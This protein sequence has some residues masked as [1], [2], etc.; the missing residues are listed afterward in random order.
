VAIKRNEWMMKK[1]EMDFE[2]LCVDLKSYRQTLTDHK[3]FD[4]KF[5]NVFRNLTLSVVVLID[6]HV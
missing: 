4:G 6:N 5:M 2:N 1:A 3:E